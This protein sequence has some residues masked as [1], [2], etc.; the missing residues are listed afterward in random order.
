MHTAAEA[1]E[2]YAANISSNR[3]FYR[4]SA[5]SKGEIEVAH[6]L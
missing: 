1:G 5:I 2:E 6:E 4:Y 3:V